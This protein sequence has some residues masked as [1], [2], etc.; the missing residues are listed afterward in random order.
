MSL[1]GRKFDFR[2][3][4]TN[5]KNPET[6]INSKEYNSSISII[7]KTQKFL[8]LNWSTKDDEFILNMKN[9]VDLEEKLVPL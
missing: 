5:D 8:G 9:L 6:F 7:D 4:I 1:K 2:K 3:W